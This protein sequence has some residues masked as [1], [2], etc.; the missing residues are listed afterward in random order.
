LKRKMQI[1]LKIKFYFLFFL[2]WMYL[3]WFFL[4]FSSLIHSLADLERDCVGGNFLCTGVFLDFCNR[5]FI[6]LLGFC[7]WVL[8]FIL[9]IFLGI[10]KLLWKG[11][12]DFKGFFFSMNL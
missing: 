9:G 2:G 4:L 7:F 12:Y 5:V 11:H 6:E 3:C 8:N 1:F 10:L